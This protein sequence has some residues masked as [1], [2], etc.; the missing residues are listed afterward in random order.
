MARRATIIDSLEASGVPYLHLDLGDFVSTQKALAEHVSRT[1]WEEMVRLDVDAVSPGRREL[2]NWPFLSACLAGGE[3]P[4]VA[5][6]LARLG[7]DG[8]RTPLGHR[9]LLEEVGGVRVGLLALLGANDFANAGVSPEAGLVFQ[10]PVEAVREVLPELRARAEITVLLSQLT[11]E[12]TDSLL[13]AVPGIDIALLGNRSRVAEVA[14]TSAGTITNEAGSRGQHAGML[15]LVVTPEGTISSYA[16]ANRALDHRV[17][18]DAET[19]ARVEAA[20]AISDE[21]LAEERLAARREEIAAEGATRY[22]GAETCKR[23]HLAEWEQWR[24]TPHAKAFGTLNGNHGMTR[25][26]DC[27][28]CH[29]TGWQAPGGFV[30]ATARPDLRNVQCEACHGP[31]T[32]HVRTGGK[33]RMDE[34]TCTGCHQ[35]EFA[36]DW[37]F[38]T[39]YELVRHD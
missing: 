14:G 18:A 28:G 36:K 10:D 6:N 21:L 17:A 9:Y 1:L 31:G 29:V 7:P 26:D 20:N 13:A 39:F 5:T 19:Q 2:G 38:E 22:L 24:T 27:T 23:C 25:T 15:R 30:S 3:I 16:A 8:T 35:G 32:E 33:S 37:N 12:D 34:A 11:R 4:F